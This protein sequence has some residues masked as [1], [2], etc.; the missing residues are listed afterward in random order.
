MADR[1]RFDP[2]D[3]RS[4]LEF[5]ERV[6]AMS[7]ASQTEVILEAEKS[8]LTRF[9]NSQIHQ[10][11]RQSDCQLSIR[12][13]ENGCVGSVSTNDFND[14]SL[15]HAF[16]WAMTVA[17]CGRTPAEP[18]DLP[19]AQQYGEITNHCRATADFPPHERALMAKRLIEECSS[20]GAEA[21]GAVSN[22]EGVVAI[23]NSKGLRAYHA[24]TDSN[25]TATV[26]VESATGWCDCYSVDV[27]G[28]DAEN[29]GKRALERALAAKNPQRVSTGRYTVILEEA[30]IKELIDI[31]TWL[32]FGAQA[33][34]EG[35][36]FM[37]G[38]FGKRITGG[39]V[40][41]ADDAY[42]PIGIGTPF[43]YEGMPKKRVVL[44]ENGVAR[45]VVYDR[46]FA[47][48]A[49]KFS[50]GHALPAGFTE[51]PLPL[52]T[53]MNP[54]TSKVHDMLRSVERGLLVTRFWYCR[55]V[56]PAKTLLTGRTRDGTF[57]IE[58]GEIVRGVRDMRFNESMLEGCARGEAIAGTV[59]RIGSAI[60]PVMKIADFRFTECVGEG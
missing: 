44:I 43:D 3:D 17:R 35:R 49:G 47:S 19:G 8:S 16:N 14:D 7:P 54:G 51:G 4:T 55:V 59:R 22:S 13:I 23:T 26:S 5:L 40:T 29:M 36:S 38:K 27:S 32:G 57:F 6:V 48:R 12:V 39:N 42:E 33:V 58:N 28:L 60:V 34:E 1:I 53:V 20:R 10:N 50:T 24:L 21:A 46:A 11:V 37:C 31:L 15:H 45:E 41:I 25:F 52:N 56:D 18:P 30:A 9:A 2:A